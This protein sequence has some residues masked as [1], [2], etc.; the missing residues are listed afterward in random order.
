MNFPQIGRVAFLFRA[1]RAWLWSLRRC[2]RTGLGRP[3]LV[4]PSKQHDCG[5]NQHGA[6]QQNGPRTRDAD[7]WDG[8][9]SRA[10]G[11]SAC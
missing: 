2:Q 11:L 6:R 5:E 9:S 7:R 8:V 3:Q 1:K 10:N 4:V